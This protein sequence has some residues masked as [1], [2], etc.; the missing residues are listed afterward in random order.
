MTRLVL[1][2]VCSRASSVSVRMLVTVLV[3][4]TFSVMLVA[5][6]STRF[7]LSVSWISRCTRRSS[8]AS[9]VVVSWLIQSWLAL[10][11][12]SQQRRRQRSALFVVSR[13]TRKL[14]AYLLYNNAAHG[15]IS[16]ERHFLFV[17]ETC[18]PQISGICGMLIT[19][20]SEICVAC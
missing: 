18:C 12:R 7:H 11:L 8:F 19:S 10:R 9:I 5:V 1:R 14:K 6:A 16:C 20:V 15:I 13:R 17:L 2:A 4:F 3:S